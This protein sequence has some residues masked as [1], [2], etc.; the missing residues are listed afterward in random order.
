MIQ[1]YKRSPQSPRSK[2]ITNASILMP[3]VESCGKLRTNKLI[4]NPPTTSI[5]DIYKVPGGPH[6][7]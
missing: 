7:R 5:G 1:I 6:R 2:I 4:V 3:C